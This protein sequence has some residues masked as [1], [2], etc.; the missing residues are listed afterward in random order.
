[1]WLQGIL[2][3][4]VL[5]AS[6]TTLYKLHVYWPTDRMLREDP[7]FYWPVFLGIIVA[8]LVTMGA[9]GGILASLGLK[10]V[11][12]AH[13][14][15]K[16]NWLGAYVNSMAGHTK[17]FCGTGF[18]VGILSSMFLSVF[19]IVGFLFYL[20]M[21]ANAT[22][23]LAVG[24]FLGILLLGCVAILGA[25]FVFFALLINGVRRLRRTEWYPT[26]CPTRLAKPE[27]EASA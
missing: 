9:F 22:Q 24:K 6:S 27:D 13:F 8:A 15:S 3:T 12:S 1:M 10:K 14:E 23:F 25:C 18:T 5:F 21:D 26:V 11:N 20:G 17:S 2:S 16:Q 7:A 19:G 4:I